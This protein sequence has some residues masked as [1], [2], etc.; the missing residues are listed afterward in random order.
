[1]HRLRLL[2]V[3]AFAAIAFAFGCGGSDEKYYIP[4]DHQIRPYA[5][6]DT[7][8]LAGDDE[9]MDDAAEPAEEPAVEPAPAPATPAA[10]AA[11]AA[12]PA[13]SAAPAKPAKAGKPAKK[14]KGKAGSG[15]P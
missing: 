4:A 12:A 13:E 11:P 7:E 6:P 10:A 15:S 14:S 3:A 1:M 9:M 5:A 8:E 2:S